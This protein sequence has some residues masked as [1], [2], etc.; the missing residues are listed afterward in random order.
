MADSSTQSIIIGASPDRVA[1]V[2]CDFPSYPEWTDAVRAAEVIEEY[3]DGYAS[4]VRFVLDATVMA[5]EYVLA[6]AYAEDL[7]R[8]E[9]HLV[10]PSKMQRAQRGAYDLEANADGSTTVT[11]TLEV[12]LAVGMLGMFRRKAEKMIMDAALKQLKRRVEASGAA[13]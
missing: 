10:A 3:E 12:E 5:D 6:Y 11:Y 7:S 9:W 13:Q 8:I 4:Q 2:I 1:A